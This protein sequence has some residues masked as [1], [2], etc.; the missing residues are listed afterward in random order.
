MASRLDGEKAALQGLQR[1]F[2][3][4]PWHSQRKRKQG[5]KTGGKGGETQDLK[6]PK[7]PGVMTKKVV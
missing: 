4:V 3:S 2:D 5:V 6:E 1:R 7:E